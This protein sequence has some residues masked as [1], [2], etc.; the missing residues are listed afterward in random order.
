M[1]VPRGS[2][3]PRVPRALKE[4]RGT[5]N[6]TRE[7]KAQPQSKS[8]LPPAPDYLNP[9]QKWSWGKF[10]RVI[11]PMR[12]TTK[13]DFASLEALAIAY[14]S[15]VLLQD[16]IRT[17]KTGADYVYAT[18]SGVERVKPAFKAANEVEGKMLNLLGRFGLTPADRSRVSVVGNGEGTGSTNPEDEFTAGQS[19]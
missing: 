5:I 18:E 8:E 12:I 1:S 11:A 13:E 6:V 7:N 15:W 2:S 9:H 3:L 14:S 17:W 19:H 16:E 10:V 4:Q